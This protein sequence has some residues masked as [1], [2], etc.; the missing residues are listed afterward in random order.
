MYFLSIKKFDI[1]FNSQVI[2]IHTYIHIYIAHTAMTVHTNAQLEFRSEVQFA[3]ILYS[4]ITYI[5]T[6]N[7]TKY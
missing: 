3:Q 7:I 4:T 2:I 1:R 6:G 5:S